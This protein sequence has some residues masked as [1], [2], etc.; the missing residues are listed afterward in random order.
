MRGA[1]TVR[2]RRQCCSDT[3]ARTYPKLTPSWHRS[4]LRRRYPWSCPSMRALCGAAVL[5]CAFF[6]WACAVVCQR[7]FFIFQ[8]RRFPCKFCTTVRQNCVCFRRFCRE[9]CICCRRFCRS[10]PRG[11]CGFCRRFCHTCGKA[12]HKHSPPSFSLS[13]STLP[14]LPI[15]PQRR[16][17]N[18]PTL[19]LPA[20]MVKPLSGTTTTALSMT[21]ACPPT[22]IPM[23]IGPPMGAVPGA[24]S[25]VCRGSHPGGAATAGIP[26]CGR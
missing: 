7:S 4:V 3:R 1:S 15:L 14:W 24:P 13:R 12:Y 5:D 19:R 2:V 20:M 23:K 16:R 11:F 22:K 6:D 10:A 26:P 18:L 8:F 9:I 17:R 21:L 25:P